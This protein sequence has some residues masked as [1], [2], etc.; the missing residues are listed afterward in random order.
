[1]EN[2]I[3][4]V[5]TISE[6][7]DPRTSDTTGGLQPTVIVPAYY[8]EDDLRLGLQQPWVGIS[9]DGFSQKPESPKIHPRCFG[10][11]AKVLGYFSRDEG[12]FTLEEAVR[13]MTGL[14]AGQLKLEN[15]GK[16]AKG[17]AA[18]ITIFDA[19]TVNDLATYGSP[20]VY[21]A[22]I[23]Y[24]IVNG[25]PVIYAGQLTGSRPGQILRLKDK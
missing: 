1:M 24:V 14:I 7:S 13:K 17:Y 3:E 4:G 12:L 23:K 5:L 22:G 18:D 15:R 6:Y 19:G 8:S 2:I 9:C 20:N 25:R 11:Y 10:S 16:L 21:P